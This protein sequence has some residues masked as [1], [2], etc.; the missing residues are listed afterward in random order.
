M[1]PL[2]ILLVALFFSLSYCDDEDESKACSILAAS[3]GVEDCNSR[4]NAKDTTEY[5]CCFAK[6]KLAG[7]NL[8]GCISLSK[9]QYDDIDETIEKAKKQGSLEDLDIDCNSNYIILSLI[10]LILLL[11]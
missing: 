4:K 1:K 7:A 10:S 3:T 11:I 9:D 8:Q 5:A 2:Y 6:Y